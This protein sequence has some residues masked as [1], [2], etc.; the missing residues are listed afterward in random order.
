MRI[1]PNITMQN[2]LYNIQR[3]RTTMDSTNEKIASG[4]NYNRPSD[5]PVA[6]RLLIGLS[7]RL[8]ANE[9]YA[10][11][12]DKASIALK[13]MDAPL[14]A[15]ITTLSNVRSLASTAS[16]GTLDDATRQNT[17]SQLT[18]FREQL[19]DYGNTQIGNQY[20]FAGTM[21][22][23]KPFERAVQTVPPPVGFNYYNGNNGTISVEIDAGVT[24]TTN[25]PGSQVLTGPDVNILKTLDELIDKLEN[26]PTDITGMQALTTQLDDGA[27]Q[28]YNAQVTNGNRITRIAALDTMLYNSNNTI[29]TVLGD[30]QNADYAKLAVQLQQQT[31]ALE[32][33]LSTTAKV[34]Q[35]SLLDYL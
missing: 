30:V 26:N 32:A 7:D 14:T 19:A 3:T 22:T 24:E 29:Q 1:T 15:M 12:I 2:S 27:Q 6:A 23:T 5:D 8:R 16:S 20:I 21:T 31:L 4:M 9:Q 10:S 18:A 17:I 28:L 35:M 33:T 34:S 25:I 11:N 13:M